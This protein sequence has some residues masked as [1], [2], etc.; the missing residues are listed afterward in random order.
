[1]MLKI[2]ECMGRINY[3]T[4]SDAGHKQQMSFILFFCPW[5]NL[6]PE[7]PGDRPEAT[8]LRGAQDLDATLHPQ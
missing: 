7:R 8:Q 2:S 5:R 6:A 3:L 4:P 1:M